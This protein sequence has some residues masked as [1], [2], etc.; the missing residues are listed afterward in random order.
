M[1]PCAIRTLTLRSLSGHRQ[2][3]INIMRATRLQACVT[4][5]CR[6]SSPPL[7]A[8]TESYYGFSSSLLTK[9]PPAPAR[10]LARPFDVESEVYCRR[11]S[12]NFWRMRA[13]LGLACAQ[14]ANSGG[15]SRFSCISS[16]R[17]KWMWL[18]HTG[19]ELRKGR[20]RAQ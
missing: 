4:P 19:W 17:A 3:L 9:R 12:G 10:P 2:R 15:L 11:R 20:F 1:V 7:D 8:S 5:S 13:S 6:R 16:R 18:A 14:A